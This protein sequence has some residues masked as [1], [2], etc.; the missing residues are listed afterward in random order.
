MTQSD[1][2]GTGSVRSR[3]P[4]GRQHVLRWTEWGDPANPRVLVCAHGLSRNGRDFDFL[5]RALS[6]RYRVVCPDYPGRGLSDRLGDPVHYH[7]GQYL[8]DS[9]RMIEALAPETLDW[10]GTSMGG[11]IG[12]G[13]A[14]R[15]DNPVRRMVINDVGP[16]IPGAALAL[17][18]EYLRTHPSFADLEKAEEYFRTVYLGFGPLEDVHYRH[19]VEHGV[20][21]DGDGFVLEIDP[22]VIDRFVA[23]PCDDMDIWSIWDQIRIPV[24]VLRGERSGLL[25]PETMAEMCA[26]HPQAE[27]V[28]IPRCAH[29]PSLMVPEQIGL[30]SEW[31]GRDG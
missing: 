7:N 26:R 2:P 25:L 19:F 29:A 12:M 21:A 11:L 16:F 8:E 4:D 24:L 10:V 17:I 18:G 20:R 5:A 27:G 28:E 23:Q 30:V 13:I 31:L 22:A 1:T 3:T 6:D 9:L 14:A 15:T